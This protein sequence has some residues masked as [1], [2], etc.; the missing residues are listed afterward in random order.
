MDIELSDLQTKKQALL[1]LLEHLKAN[2]YQFISVTPETHS[3]V[4]RHAAVG[5]TLADIFGW[6]RWFYAADLKAPLFELLKYHDLLEQQEQLFRC[7][8]RVSSLNDEIFIHSSYPTTSQNAVFLGPDTYRFNLHLD[9]FLKQ[10]Q[11]SVSSILEM[12]SGTAATAILTTKK[13]NPQPELTL[14][15]INPYALLLSELHAEFSGIEKFRAVNSHLYQEIHEQYD[16]I[17]ANPPY[18]VDS[19]RR[20]YRHGGYKMDGAQLAFDIVQQGVT[21]LYRNGHLFLY[22]GVA[23]RNGQSV[24]QERIE[25]WFKGQSKFTWHWQ[26]IDPDIFGEELEQPYYS[27]VERIAAIILCV[28]KIA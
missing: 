14:V 22:T 23:I 27:G 19:E 4:L 9:C 21:H 5:E 6:N 11:F 20:Q 26:E 28:H 12:G 2:A 15:D 1:D 18:L 16:L 10:Q 8:F 17:I 25:E 7:K 3:R 13:F 24:L